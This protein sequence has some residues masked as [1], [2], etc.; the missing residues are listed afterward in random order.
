MRRALSQAIALAL[1]AAVPAVLAGFFHP[2]RPDFSG[3]PK[4]GEISA[5]VAV[6]DAA[7]YFWIDARSAHEY[8]E[9]HIPGAVLLNEDDWNT[10]LPAVMQ[11]W[12][13]DKPAIVYCSVRQCQASR[14][15]ARRLREFNFAPVFELKGGWEAWQAA[16]KR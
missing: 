8:A 9:Q 16:Q 7:R 14:D 15:V 1:I 13:P 2:K 4:E 5:M 10:L 3:A 11:E 12:P 6:R